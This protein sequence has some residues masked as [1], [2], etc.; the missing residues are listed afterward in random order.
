VEQSAV[1]GKYSL[2]IHRDPAVA[3]VEIILQTEKEDVIVQLVSV[4]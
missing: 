4:P 2:D 3:D 1:Y